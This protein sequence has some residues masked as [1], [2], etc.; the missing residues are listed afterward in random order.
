MVVDA[1]RTGADRWD[2]ALLRITLAVVMWPHGAQKL[3]GWFG[4]FGFSGTQGYFESLGMPA[5]LGALVIAVEFFAPLALLVGAGTRAAAALLAAVMI[6]AVTVGGHWKYGFFMNWVG[7]QGGE[8]F[9][10]HLLF[11]AM[12]AVLVALGG[13]AASVDARLS[14]A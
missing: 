4:G 12:S 7:A 14:R 11:L 10:Y 1:L 8:G 5:W 3:L 6:G 2:L 13:G 9:E